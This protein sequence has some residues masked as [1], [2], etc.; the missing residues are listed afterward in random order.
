MPADKITA[1]APKVKIPRRVK[2]EIFSLNE[3]VKCPANAPIFSLAIIIKTPIM[4]LY[5][6]M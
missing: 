1:H 3:T 5:V 6:K 4:K 2:F